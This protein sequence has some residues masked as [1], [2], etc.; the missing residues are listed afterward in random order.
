MLTE[1]FELDPIEV[2]SE[3]VGRIISS[4][5]EDD[6]DFVVFDA[7]IYVMIADANMLSPLVLYRVRA[8]E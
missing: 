1:L 6:G 8:N 7:F 3:H 2:L 4:R 5:D